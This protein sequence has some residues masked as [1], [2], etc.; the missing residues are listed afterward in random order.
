MQS[1]FPPHQIIIDVLVVGIAEGII[2]NLEAEQDT[3][4]LYGLPSGIIIV[5]EAMD[6]PVSLQGLAALLKIVDGVHH[7]E[8]ARLFHDEIRVAVLLQCQIGQ[9]IHKALEQEATVLKLTANKRQQRNIFSP[10]AAFEVGIAHFV[11]AATV[12]KSNGEVVFPVQ[13]VVQFLTV[14]SAYIQINPSGAQIREQC[15]V[16]KWKNTD[17]PYSSRY[18]RS[19]AFDGMTMFLR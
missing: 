13:L 17:V 5:E 4:F 18:I 15:H 11:I 1:L 7:K 19:A 12:R 14:A 16:R 6:A 2:S 8:V 3:Q 9:E 10:E